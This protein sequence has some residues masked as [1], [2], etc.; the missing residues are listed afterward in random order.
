MFFFYFGFGE[1]AVFRRCVVRS[2][3]RFL[4]AAMSVF[5]CVILGTFK[6]MFPNTNSFCCCS[7]LGNISS[8]LLP[9]LGVSFFW[10]LRSV[11][12]YVTVYVA[13]Y[14]PTARLFLGAVSFLVYS[15]P[16]FNIILRCIKL[17][18]CVCFFV[19]LCVGISSC[20][21]RFV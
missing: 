18:L 17:F 9:S 13:L 21:R 4:F 6:F 8:S 16:L 5:Y 15:L 11:A 3:S 19:R 10:V 2:F 12:T 14:V 1:D 20:F 7:G